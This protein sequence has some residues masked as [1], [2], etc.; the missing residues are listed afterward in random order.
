MC[1]DLSGNGA[2][3]LQLKGKGWNQGLACISREIKFFKNFCVFYSL[4]LM[5]KLD[6]AGIKIENLRFIV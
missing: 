5:A 1:G 4:F 2:Q 3:V 6:C